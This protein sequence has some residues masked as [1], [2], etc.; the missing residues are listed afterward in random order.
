M[1]HYLIFILAWGGLLLGPAAWAQSANDKAPWQTKAKLE[2]HPTIGV[3]IWGSYTMGQEV[4]NA[5]QQAY[6]G[7]DDRLNFQLRR[8]RFGFK[9]SAYERLKYNVLFSADLVGRDLLAGTE[10]GSNNGG[11]P[12]IGLWN[13]YVQWQVLPDNDLFDVVFGYQVPQIGRESITGALRSTSMEKSWSQNYLRRHLVGRGPG[14][15]LGVNFGG[16]ILKENRRWNWSY[17]VGIFNPAFGQLGGQSVGQRYAP[18]LT[19]RLVTYWG[20]PESK[21]YSTGHKINYFGQRKGLSLAVAAAHQGESDSYRRNGAWSA[22]F[23]F[24][25][26][27]WNMDGEW[28]LLH[29]SSLSAADAATADY[30][31][32]ATTGY[33]R[34]SYNLAMPH[35]HFLE[36]VAMIVWLEGATSA[37]EQAQAANLGAF[38]GR[39]RIFDFGFNYYLNPDLKFSLHYTHRWG[40]SGAAGDGANINNFFFQ[41]GV[42]A[43]RRGNW[44]GVGVITIL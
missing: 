33:L 28:T 13:A 24:N 23:L 4:Y 10:G 32:Q 34:L 27:P 17:D 9:G 5:E 20:D 37:D 25:H 12:N 3:Q 19:G 15:S 7:V 41:N 39:E 21:R 22:D 14:R 8:T 44:L 29:R 18:L 38:A 40:D 30:T 6:E 43:I 42:G 11:Q 31:T 35:E 26:G 2:L 16:L 1:K 36:P